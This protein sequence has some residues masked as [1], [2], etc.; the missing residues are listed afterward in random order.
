V[1]N[2]DKREPL[3]NKIFSFATALFLDEVSG[4]QNTYRDFCHILWVLRLPVE[5][6]PLIFCG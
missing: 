6:G 1:S 4:L 3:F 5:S 2:N